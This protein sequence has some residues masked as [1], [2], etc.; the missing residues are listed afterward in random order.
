VG[1]AQS[2]NNEI[3]EYIHNAR[4]EKASEEDFLTALKQCILSFEKNTNVKIKLD[5]PKQFSWEN[6]N[7]SIRINILNIVREA[8]NNIR[9][10][11]EA[12]NAVISF[13]FTKEQLYAVVEDDGKG[14]DPEG[15][16][17]GTNKKFGLS[18]MRERASE[19]GAK[20]DIQSTPGKGS[21]VVLCV[22]IKE[23]GE[24]ADK[25]NAGR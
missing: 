15:H 1:V 16:D 10:H 11:A 14:F 22:P 13:S 12:E 19:I 18:I 23:D 24:N 3:R 7:L 20:I 6:L 8:L 25:G 5:V 21:R 2:A 17:A 9:K 4:N